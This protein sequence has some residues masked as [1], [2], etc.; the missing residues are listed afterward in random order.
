[1]TQ[2]KTHKKLFLRRS[3]EEE[4]GG[5]VIMAYLAILMFLLLTVL[6]L[7]VPYIEKVGRSMQR[8]LDTAALSGA[9]QLTQKNDPDPAIRKKGWRN[10]KKSVFAFMKLNP[11][12]SAE[13]LN[14][15]IASVTPSG[16]SNPYDT[17]GYQYE[18]YTITGANS[19][20]A[21]LTIS[22][23][24]YR[25]PT[26]WASASDEIKI[27][28]RTERGG[29]DSYLSADSLQ[30]IRQVSTDN[31]AYNAYEPSECSTNPSIFDVADSVQLTMTINNVP[32]LFG[33]I[34]GIVG[35]TPATSVSLTRTALSVP[36]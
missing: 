30:C 12:F 27:F 24:V 16:L 21:K 3:R 36:E 28:Y 19:I 23:G 20:T 32:T 6:M 8:S 26:N 25:R 22:R 7:D 1:M 14:Y 15:D 11:V 35:T 9:I 33:K 13:S 18:E 29:L 2:N 10:A 5:M 34:L 4:S 31:P 17:A